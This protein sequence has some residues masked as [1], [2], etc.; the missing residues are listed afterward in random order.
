MKK[1]LQLPDGGTL[2]LAVSPEF[3]SPVFAMNDSAPGAAISSSGVLMMGVV[4][5]L[6]TWLFFKMLKNN[7]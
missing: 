2:D 1:K 4:A 7:G 5:M 6:S 3:G